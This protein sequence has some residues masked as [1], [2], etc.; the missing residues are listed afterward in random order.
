[1]V[2]L[3]VVLVVLVELV[4]LVRL[5]VL[6]EGTDGKKGREKGDA[7][8][9]GFV[10]GAT[11]GAREGCRVVVGVRVGYFVGFREVGLDG[12]LVGY[13][14]GGEL[15]GRVKVGSF[16]VITG[17]VAAGQVMIADASV[18]LVSQTVTL[19]VRTLVTRLVLVDEVG[20]VDTVCVTLVGEL[21][22]A[23]I[24]VGA[25]VVCA[26][27]HTQAASTHKETSEMCIAIYSPLRVCESLSLV[28]FPDFPRP[29]CSLCI[30][31]E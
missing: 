12:T 31:F 3:T 13:L 10:V 23:V 30:A 7:V 14:V 9:V 2:V 16:V 4:E 15:V 5:G 19:T 24:L 20:D 8:P 11:W 21:E 18:H 28:C 29:C 26:C 22:R 25:F 27:I 1:M 6:A 17:G